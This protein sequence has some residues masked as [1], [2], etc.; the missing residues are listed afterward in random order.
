V[1][2]RFRGRIAI[3]FRSRCLDFRLS[4]G[5]S[6]GAFIPVIEIRTRLRPDKA[7]VALKTGPSFSFIRPG[8]EATMAVAAL[9]KGRWVMGDYGRRSIVTVACSNAPRVMVTRSASRFSGELLVEF[10]KPM[11]R[12]N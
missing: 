3:L 12:G 8:R 9:R 1:V 2:V 11:M 5:V 4:R 7:V 6:F 10:G